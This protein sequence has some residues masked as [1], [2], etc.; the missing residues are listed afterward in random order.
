MAAQMIKSFQ[1][2]IR[3]TSKEIGLCRRCLYFK[4]HTISKYFEMIVEIKGPESWWIGVIKGPKSWWIG[5][6]ITISRVLNQSKV[7]PQRPKG[8]VD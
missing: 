2:S 3:S 8:V 5:K 1:M 7:N 6:S 4:Q